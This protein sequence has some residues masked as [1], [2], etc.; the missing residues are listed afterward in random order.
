MGGQPETGLRTAEDLL[1]AL[2]A[3]TKPGIAQGL[4]AR[5]AAPCSLVRFGLRA[6]ALFG[7]AAAQVLDPDVR[8]GQGNLKVVFCKRA[9][10]TLLTK[11]L[12]LKKF[13][14]RHSYKFSQDPLSEPVLYLH[15]QELSG[16]LV[17]SCLCLGNLGQRKPVGCQGGWTGS[18]ATEGLQTEPRAKR[19]KSGHLQQV[20]PCCQHL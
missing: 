11:A 3:Q 1:E 19:P 17:R 20:V 7:Q 14:L 13:V 2:A 9:T 8:K 4:A 6:P 16:Q 15:L 12:S 18:P 10:D 5:I